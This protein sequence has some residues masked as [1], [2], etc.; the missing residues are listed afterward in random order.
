MAEKEGN[1]TVTKSLQRPQPNS[2]DGGAARA[3]LSWDK[4]FRLL[5]VYITQPLDTDDPGGQHGTLD[6][7]NHDSLQLKA[8]PGE[9]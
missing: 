2:W 7:G 3:V 8:V 9:G 1:Y 6:E 5:S 4:G